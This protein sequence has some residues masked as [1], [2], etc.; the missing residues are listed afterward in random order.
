[1]SAKK[2][3]HYFMRFFFYYC[4]SAKEFFSLFYDFFYYC[5]SA[6]EIFHYFMRFFFY[7]MS[8][9]FSLWLFG[10]EMDGKFVFIKK[11]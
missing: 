10:F 6:N 1:M 2:K 8:V 9:G 3:I 7:C 11:V 5:M 4:M